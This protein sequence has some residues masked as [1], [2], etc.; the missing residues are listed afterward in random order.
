MQ[1]TPATEDLP[2]AEDLPDKV[3][4]VNSPVQSLSISIS[5]TDSDAVHPHPSPRKKIRV[6]IDS[7]DENH[8]LDSAHTSPINKVGI[9]PVCVNQYC[10]P[11]KVSFRC[12]TKLF[13]D[14][15]NVCFFS[16]SSP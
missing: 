1:S 7:Y 3:D 16:H 8:D 4:A 10:V 6:N 12:I 13:E 2:P 9:Q 11:F 5:S 15:Y 14:S